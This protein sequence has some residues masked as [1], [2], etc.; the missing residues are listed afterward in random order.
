M[1]KTS[2]YLTASEERRLDE[3]ARRTGRSKA[4]LVREAITSY[5]PTPASGFS[6]IGAGEGPG[7]S[8]ADH[9]ERELLE[10][11]GE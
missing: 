5:D 2:L 8:V 4:Q 11:F 7:D 10:G 9:D 6:F 3:L 1:R